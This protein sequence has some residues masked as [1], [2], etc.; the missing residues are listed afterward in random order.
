MIPGA[1]SETNSTGSPR[2]RWLWSARSETSVLAGAQQSWFGNAPDFDALGARIEASRIL[3]RRTRTMVRAAWHDRQHRTRTYL[4]GPVV[5]VSLDGSWVATL[6]ICADVGLGWGHERP[7]IRALASRAR[8][9]RASAEVALPRGFNLGASV[10]QRWADCEGNWSPFVVTGQPREDRTRSVRLFLRPRRLAWKGFSPQ[11]S[12]VHE[13]RETNA[14]A[15]DYRRTG[16]EL[17]A[18]RL[19]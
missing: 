6:T 3:T 17:R 14:Q 16:G 9:L 13:A 4:D 10:G 8:W 5:D 19:F 15:Y 11:L 7:G 12:L 18:V 2:S 1:P